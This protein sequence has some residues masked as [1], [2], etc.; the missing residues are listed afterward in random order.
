MWDYE[1]YKFTVKVYVGG[2]IK[3]D[4]DV[5]YD[6]Y[7][8]ALDAAIGIVDAEARVGESLHVAITLVGVYY[9]GDGRVSSATDLY[10]LYD[11]YTACH[12]E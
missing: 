10:T 2:E 7:Q 6:D 11:V 3:S 1:D 4:K 9:K 8:T 12:G 5:L